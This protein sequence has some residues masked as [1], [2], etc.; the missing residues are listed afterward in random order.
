MNLF[1]Y[2]PTQNLLPFDGTVNYFGP[3]LT[4]HEAQDYLEVLEDV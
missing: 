2:E 3:I 4:P 1:Q